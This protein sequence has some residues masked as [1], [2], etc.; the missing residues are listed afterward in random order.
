MIFQRITDIYR[1]W[2]ERRKIVVGG[3]LVLVVIGLFSC[4]SP[5]NS[6]PTPIAVPDSIPAT[7]DP[8]TSPDYP[9]FIGMG[10]SRDFIQN[11]FSSES[12]GF[13]FRD[14]PLP[15]GTPRVLGK[16]GNEQALLYLAGPPDDLTEVTL[17]LHLRGGN[18][19]D[20]TLYFRSIL[21]STV[22]EWE[23]ALAWLD[24]SL[25]EFAKDVNKEL[26]RSTTYNGKLLV[27]IGA[28]D[29]GVMSLAIAG[30]PR[31][32]NRSALALNPTAESTAGLGLSVAEFQ[33]VFGSS[34]FNWRI[35]C[36]SR[37]CPYT[38]GPRWVI[39]QTRSSNIV[40]GSSPSAIHLHGDPYDLTEVNISVD[41]DGNRSLNSLHLEAFL[42]LTMPEWEERFDWITEST[43][44]HDPD[45]RIN[46]QTT[47]HNGKRI[48]YTFNRR[49][50]LAGIVIKRE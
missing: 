35:H 6:V 43:K 49:S 47:T 31:S 37:F 46:H 16:P 29:L 15:D 44:K 8:F 33:K 23:E 36:P 30:D 13:T 10:V 11:I 2:S 41:M 42:N 21:F 50:G 5:S 1:A 34:Q 7:V 25:G 9:A 20:T 40:Q 26:R 19:S 12:L 17:I 27:F 32:P 48:M 28:P 39:G 3:V 22:T 18:A 14:A 4:T 45:Q 24:E 38:D